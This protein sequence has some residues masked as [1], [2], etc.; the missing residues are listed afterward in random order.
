MSCLWQRHFT[1]QA[2][3]QL[4]FNLLYGQTVRK[5]VVQ[6]TEHGFGGGIQSTHDTGISQCG[7]GCIAALMHPT[8]MAL[9]QVNDQPPFSK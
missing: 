9:G 6:L 4:L 1:R 8:A 3:S 7:A 2:V 5:Q